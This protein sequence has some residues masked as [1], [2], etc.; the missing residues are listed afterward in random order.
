[1]GKGISKQF[2]KLYRNEDTGVNYISRLFEY[3]YRIYYKTILKLNYLPNI[4]KPFDIIGK[5][6]VQIGQGFSAGPGVR[7]EAWINR[8]GEKYDPHIIIG[9]NVL[10]QHRTHITAIN[11]VILG[12]DVLTGSDVLI[13]DNNHGENRS[14]LELDKP[15]RKRKLSSKGN[16]II[17]DNVWIGDKAVILGGVTIGKGSVIGANS[18]VTKS[19]PPYSTAVGNPAKVIRTVNDDETLGDASILALLGDMK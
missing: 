17:E 1:M 16:I 3:I 9:D 8:L 14:V 19:I 11:T 12:N 15:P 2:V 13:S 5:E 10:L 7:I 18:V 6:R 4:R